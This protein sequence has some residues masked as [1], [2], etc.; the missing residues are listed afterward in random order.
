M[1]KKYLLSIDEGTSSARAILFDLEGKIVSVGRKSFEMYYPEAG[2]VEQNALEILEA[3]KIAIQEAI[4]KAQIQAHEILAIGITNQRETIVCWNKETGLPIYN[5]IVWQDSRTTSFCEELKKQNLQNFIQSKTGLIIDPYFSASKLHWIFTYV[6]EAKKLLSENKLL[7]GTIDCWLVW[8]FTHRKTYAT[9]VTNASRT[10]LFNI[11]QLKWDSELMKI[12][13]L[14]NA[15]E[16][17]FPEIKN[18]SDFYGIY[19]DLQ[20]PIYS[21]I[22]D[23]QSATFG[24]ACFKEGMVKNTYGT[25]C[26]ILMNTG[27]VPYISNHQLL[28]TIAWKIGEELTYALEGAIFSAGA[29]IQWLEEI[30]IVKDVKELTELA[31]SIAENEGVYLVPA[32]A[33]LGAPQWDPTARGTILGL[34][35]GSTKAHLA[36]AA[37]E[38][39]AFQSQEILEIMSLDSSIPI[40]ELRVDGGASQDPLLMQFQADVSQVQIL[41]P[42]NHETTALGAALMAGLGIRHY[43]NLNEIQNLWKYKNS[44]FPQKSPLWAQ[45]QMKK[46]KKAVHRALQWS[47]EIL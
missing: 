28:T 11:H 20:A 19:E 22:G 32:F 3:Q 26:F 43:K 15:P 4:H 47:E 40:K 12:F 6:P 10:M 44:F 31:A 45:Y 42:Q 27:K 16:D 46:W 21:V 33:G 37:I 35:R 29:S 24:Q 1:Q 9:D 34:T 23:Q 25:G 13:Q 30:G 14:E 5:A 36:R 18:S 7:W 38:S 2:W 39:M 41:Q 17:F 8:N